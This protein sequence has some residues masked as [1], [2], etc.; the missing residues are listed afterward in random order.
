MTLPVGVA[1]RMANGSLAEVQSAM[2][3]V[4]ESNQEDR[5]SKLPSQ[6]MGSM[7]F[8][9]NL[10]N[11]AIH[12]R[13]RSGV[14]DAVPKLEMPR[15]SAKRSSKLDILLKRLQSPRR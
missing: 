2:Q 10:R 11:Q 5:Y 8:S 7:A 15:E 1:G 13:V 9:R 12:S 4:E 6:M 14:M 3:M